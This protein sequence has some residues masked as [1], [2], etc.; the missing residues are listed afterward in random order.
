MVF[1]SLLCCVKR[2]GWNEDTVPSK[3]LTKL[4]PMITWDDHFEQAG[5]TEL[6]KIVCNI[7]GCDL[8][9]EVAA[10]PEEINKLDINSKTPLHYASRAR[11]I[12]HI[13][14]LLS[15]GADPNASVWPILATPIHFKDVE[16]IKC[17]LEAGARILRSPKESQMEDNT[18]QNYLEFLTFS[19]WYDYVDKVEAERVN[20]TLAIDRLLIAHEFDLNC[21]RITGETFVMALAANR[22]RDTPSASRLRL[23]LENHADAELADG[24]G[25]RALHHSVKGSNTIAFERLVS[26]EAQLDAKTG[27]GSTVLHLAVRHILDVDL[28]RAMLEVDLGFIDLEAKD[29]RGLTAFALLKMRAG[30]RRDLWG[31]FPEIRIYHSWDNDYVTQKTDSDI[32]DGLE[33]LLRRIQE[34]QGIPVEERY[35]PLFNA[36][37]FVEDNGHEEDNLDL[38]TRGL[39]G[40]W[41]TEL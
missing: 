39:P 32:V 5:F 6:H 25:L 33:I 34:A 24:V 19:W 26:F 41:P 30:K 21:Q 12:T 3:P 9:T 17:L 15:H 36:A 7:S 31:Y 1:D 27:N 38:P 37:G 8:E 29:H 40:T 28:V 10:R 4:L 20:K 14:I 13:R 22:H 23:A 35:P 11:N 2:R 16:V 18:H